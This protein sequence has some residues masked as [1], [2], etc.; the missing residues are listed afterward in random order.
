[1]SDQNWRVRRLGRALAGIGAITIV[2]GFAGCSN[3]KASDN[4]GDAGANAGAA[5]AEVE[6]AYDALLE[7]NWTEPPSNPNPAVADKTVMVISCGEANDNC[8]DMGGGVTKAADIL[9]WDVILCDG[10]LDPTVAQ[11]CFRQAVSQ[12]V[13]GIVN[14]AWDCPIVKAPL[15]QAV[16]AGI[17]VIGIH[18][19]DCG[20]LNPGEENLFNVKLNYGDLAED[21]PDAWRAWGGA[22]AVAALRF[23]GDGAILYPDDTAEFASFKF[24]KEGWDAKVEELA[25]DTEVVP[26]LW[27][28]SEVGPKLE[29]KVQAAILKNPE[30]SVVAAAVNPALGFLNGVKQS[31]KADSITVVEGHGS[32]TEGDWVRS[33]EMGALVGWPADWWGYGALDALNSAFAGTPVDPIGIGFGIIDESNLYPSG[34]AFQGQGSDLDLAGAYSA[35]WGK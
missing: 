1:M 27:T 25:P 34:E 24:Q 3:T 35:R 21:Q 29:A 32:I 22:M 11:A 19:F 17:K 12:D 2:L 10:K 8:I 20:E 5:S 33:G 7:G 30:I 9:G 31:G 6:A 4:G 23:A 18:A 15:E 28:V 26:L 14:L 16:N 13:D